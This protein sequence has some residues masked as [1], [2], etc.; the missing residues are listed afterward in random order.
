M[1]HQASC[2]RDAPGG[3]VLL[4]C[5]E[6]RCSK[7]AANDVLFQTG[8]FPSAFLPLKLRTCGRFGCSPAGGLAQQCPQ[9]YYSSCPVTYH[10]AGTHSHPLQPIPAV[11]LSLCS[12]KSKGKKGRSHRNSLL[13]LAMW[14]SGQVAVL[15]TPWMNLK[16]NKN[17]EVWMQARF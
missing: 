1:C 16:H 12:K 4:S 7:S 11:P 8:P 6:Q 3:N 10:A 5:K 13:F 2:H 17:Q 9:R 15:H 14:C